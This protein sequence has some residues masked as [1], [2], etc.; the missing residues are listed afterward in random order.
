MKSHRYLDARLWFRGMVRAIIRPR[1][2]MRLWRWLD[3]HVRIPESSGGPNPGAMRTGR[4]PIFRGLYDLA[5]QKHV[6]FL[7]LCSSARAGKTLFCICLVLYWISE[8][9]GWV[10]WLDPSRNSARKLVRDELDDFLLECKPV[11]ALAVAAPPAPGCKKWW[12]TLEKAFRGKRFRIIGSGAEADLHGFNAELV[13]TNELDACRASTDKSAASTDKLEART[14]LFGNSR[15]V[16]RNS[17][18]QEG[19][20][21]PTWTK[22]LS[23]TQHHCY[24]PCP[25]C[26]DERSRDPQ[27]GYL[28]TT[29]FQPPAEEDCRPGWSPASYDPRLAGW[30]RFTFFTEKVKVP[31]D[32]ELNPLVD[33]DGVLLPR[34]QWREE[35]TGQANFERFAVYQDRQRN[36]DPTQMERVRVGWN[37]KRVRK[38]ATYQCPYCEKDIEQTAHQTWML[39]RYRWMA[40][41]PD[42]EPSL[43][44]DESEDEEDAKT[45]SMPGEEDEHVSAH[46]WSWYSPFEK[47]GV[48]SAKFL[49]ARRDFAKLMTFW[50]YHL[51]RPL[52]HNGAQLKE[53]DIER[54]IGRCPVRYLQ[55]Q[56]PLEAEML[57]MCIDRQGTE[58]WFSIRAWGI[59]WDH[60]DWPTWTALIDWGELASESQ[61]AEKAGLAP[62]A[63]GHLRRFRFTR[64]DGTVREYAVTAGLYDCGFE[65]A[66]VFDYCL[67]QTH[68]LSPSKGGGPEKT[69]G[70]PIRINEGIMDGQ[71]DLIWFWSDLFAA[72][73]YYDCILNGSSNGV[74]INWWLPA[75]IDAEYKKQ[76][77]DEHR[78][79][80]N[81]KPVWK[82]RVKND[83]GD[84]EKNHRVLSGE[85]EETLDK[86]R[87][88]RTAAEAEAAE[89][90]ST[91]L[92]KR[93]IRALPLLSEG[94][95]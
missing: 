41:N 87:D 29:P 30:Q 81:G 46:V 12:T 7:T 28:V 68:W 31:F 90:P 71:L 13:V 55:G 89:K 65:Q 44:D 67:G 60:P 10:A 27:L 1:P 56:I 21:G 62:D 51:G 16:V 8:R 39:A 4:F 15:L 61:I 49:H 11:R 79:E 95:K 17:T 50:V 85:I 47:W 43:E 32:A 3:K 54:C 24:L 94:K 18:P 69:G 76:M 6:H 40:H 23:G 53:S 33:A 75:N 74:P 84:T 37:M 9:F 82:R 35:T 38:G 66:T 80:E 36:D 2:R 63:Q 34:D 93:R 42:P 77:C 5:S 14:A 91:E 52:P 58:L 72:N 78:T 57:T 20:F 19:E 92:I 45:A 22:F 25:H 48:I 73:L 70:N 83:I 64:P 88:A 59:L 26:S 86:I